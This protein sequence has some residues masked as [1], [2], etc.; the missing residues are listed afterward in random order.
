MV[1][2]DAQGMLVRLVQGDRQDL[3]INM[4]KVG[5]LDLLVDL[6]DLVEKWD[7]DIARPAMDTTVLLVALVN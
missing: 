1:L 3:A 2:A 5:H 6:G 4:E 7:Y